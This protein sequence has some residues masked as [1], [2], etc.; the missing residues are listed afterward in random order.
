MASVLVTKCPC[1]HPGD[2]RKFNAIDLPELHH[3]IDCIVFPAHGPRRHPNEMAGSDLDEDEYIVIWEKCMF[4]VGPN[5]PP[6]NFLDRSPES[7]NK[8]ITAKKISIC[9]DFAKNGQTA[10][11]RHDER[12]LLYSD[13]MEKGSHKTTYRSDLAL[14][15]FYRTCR[16]LE[17][18]VDR[19]GHQHVDPGRCRALA[20][21]GRE[22]YRESV[23]QALTDYNSNFRRILSQYVIGSVGEVMACMVNTFDIYHNAQSDKLNMEDLVEKM[24]FLTETTRNIFYTDVITEMHDNCISD[25]EELCKRK[26]RRA[27]A[28]YM[29]TYE[30]NVENILQFSLVHC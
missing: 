11:L 1:L 26:L 7:D 12:P 17:A 20:V 23:I 14:G 9:L 28:W 19:L 8:E 21:P 3:V 13:F 6:M 10:F 2:V 27:S 25:S 30:T 16:S 24:K 22:N 29:V 5:R 15:V 4:V 18:A